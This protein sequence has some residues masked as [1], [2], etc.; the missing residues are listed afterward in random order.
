V[1]IE[2]PLAQTRG[3]AAEGQSPSPVDVGPADGPHD[4]KRADDAGVKQ[5]EREQEGLTAR[6][7]PL[8][9]CVWKS[10]FMRGS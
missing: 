10:L 6:L 8:E 5:G 1:P 7:S 3:P 4:H 2:D 9:S